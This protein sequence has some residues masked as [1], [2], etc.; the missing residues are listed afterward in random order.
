MRFIHFFRVLFGELQILSVLLQ[1]TCRDGFLLFGF[2]NL[3]NL[4]LIL[5]TG[6]DNGTIRRYNKLNK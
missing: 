3:G 4:N 1:C 6:I 5:C 2:E